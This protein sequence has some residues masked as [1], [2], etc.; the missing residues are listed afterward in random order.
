MDA[1]LMKDDDLLEKYNA[2][3]NNVSADIKKEF[4][5]EPLYNKKFENQNKISWW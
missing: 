1:F 4:H 5:R 3:C 2:I